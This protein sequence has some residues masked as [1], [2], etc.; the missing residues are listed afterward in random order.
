MGCSRTWRKRRSRNEKE[1][2]EPEHVVYFDAEQL[3][4]D[5]GGGEFLWAR[6]TMV[7]GSCPAASWAS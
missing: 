6:T 2:G 3:N 1:G 5:C 4:F 7:A